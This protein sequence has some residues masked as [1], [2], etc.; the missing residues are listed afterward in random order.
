MR[1]AILTLNRLVTIK[2]TYL[3]SFARQLQGGRTSLSEYQFPV[4]VRRIRP[5]LPLL[6]KRIRLMA[7]K[8]TSGY[9]IPVNVD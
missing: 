4:A 2:D 1:Q 6:V 8:R 5:F 3:A 9:I 7:A